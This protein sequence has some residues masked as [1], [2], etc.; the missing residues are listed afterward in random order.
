MKAKK[1]NTNVA[2]FKAVVAAAKR[3]I[4]S[5]K[6]RP[7]KLDPNKYICEPIDGMDVIFIVI[8]DKES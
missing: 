4:E 3:G 1:D 8:E 5:R 7:H 6:C 2:D